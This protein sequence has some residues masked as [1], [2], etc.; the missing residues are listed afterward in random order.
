MN[1][2]SVK[3]LGVS[4]LK[5]QGTLGVLGVLSF[6]R[7]I[8][9]YFNCLPETRII[10]QNISFEVAKGECFGIIGYNAS[11]KTTMCNVL[12]NLIP[13]ESGAVQINGCATFCKNELH[14]TFTAL[15]NIQM[16]ARLFDLCPNQVDKISSFLLAKLGFKKS[17]FTT[18]AKD[19]S[20]GSKAKVALVKSL[21]IS[22]RE[23]VE[24][25]III[26]DEPTRGFDVN[27]VREFKSC[28]STLRAL[29]PSLTIVIATNQENE[30]CLCDRYTAIVNKSQI[31]DESKLR[32]LREL[33]HQY[34]DSSAGLFESMMSG[35]QIDSASSDAM[36]MPEDLKSI[37]VVSG[38]QNPFFWRARREIISNPFLTFFLI[39]TLIV[40][41]LFPL[42]NAQ[43]KD[44]GIFTAIGCGIYFSFTM[45][46][47]YRVIVR[48]SDYFKCLN[49]ILQ[50]KYRGLRHL[51]ASTRSGFI[52]D[53]VF[54]AIA[55]GML[56]VA[57]SVKIGL[58]DLATISFSYWIYFLLLFL[59]CVL[60]SQAVGILLSPLLKTMD[61]DNA[62]FFLS[63]IPFLV[64]MLSGLYYDTDNQLLGIG[65]FAKVLP[66][67]YLGMF[68]RHGVDLHAVISATILSV[69]WYG[70]SLAM[71]HVSLKVLFQAKR[72]K[73]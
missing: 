18:M 31:E 25:P 62:F 47:F 23:G 63:I 34:V 45:R 43:T 60:F 59:S 48:E 56:A 16:A 27:A 70:L 55:I 41:N 69:A 20:F 32:E 61:K 42:L 10:F 72:L 28:I 17:D 71:Y 37:K 1:V 49:L 35:G 33:H 66:Y 65:Y 26:L 50:S 52:Q 8:L 19:L 4:V 46:T 6:L 73:E 24:S 44:W 36:D 3:N 30:L 64:L 12:A 39:L 51:F 14:G 67:T 58:P 15:E 68:I 11:G 7:D 21:V 2:I 53:T 13:Y 29:V 57:L 9:K 5:S 54:A 40:P 38:L 22:L